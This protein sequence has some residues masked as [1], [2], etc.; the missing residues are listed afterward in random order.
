MGGHSSPASDPLFHMR[1]RCSLEISLQA[2]TSVESD[3]VIVPAH[4]VQVRAHNLFQPY[5][6]P[7]S[8]AD[9]CASCDDIEFRKDAVQKSHFHKTCCVFEQDLQ[10]LRLV[11][12]RVDSGQ[13]FQA[14]FSIEDPVSGESQI[15]PLDPVSVLH[16]KGRAPHVARSRYRKFLRKKIQG[17]G[18][19]RTAFI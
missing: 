2:V 18:A 19:V 11:F 17:I 14:I 15:T 13:S 6:S 16:N 5:F 8:I 9:H 7:G 12:L 4:K 1:H 10:R 3:Q